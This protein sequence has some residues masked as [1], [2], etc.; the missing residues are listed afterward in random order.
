MT[1]Q[2]SLP[3]LSPAQ[4][5]PDAAEAV[6]EHALHRDTVHGSSSLTPTQ[7][8]EP[9]NIPRVGAGF[10][11][12]YMFAYF[13]LNLVMLMPA[14]FSL[15]Y[16]VQLI[17]PA[18]K[19]TSLGLVIGLGGI[20]GLVLGPI[21][22]VL[23]DGTRLAWGRR[24]PW[25]IGGL[26]LA[27]AGALAVAVVPT[28]PLMIVGWSICQLAVA[29]IS[30]GFNPVLAERVPSAQRGKVGALGG[31]AASFAGVGASLIGSFLTGNIML[32]FM[33]P[34][35]VFAVGVLLFIFV[36]RDKPAPAGTPRLA[37]SDVFKSFWFN[38]R[39]H[40][41][42]ALV[43]L[44]KF[45]LQFGFSF[46]STFSFYFLLD[47][48]GFTP[49]QAGQSLAA[50]GG[51]SLL[52]MMGFAVFGGFLSDRLKRRKP[53]IYLASTLI[54]AGLITVSI[55]PDIT[56]FIVG[57][58]LLSA[59]TG[60]FTS[61]DLAMATDVLPEPEKAGKYMSIYYLSSGIPGALAPIIAP[62]IIAVGGG[63]NYP[64][65]FITGAILAVGTAVTTWRIRGV[66]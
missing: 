11:A 24:R 53:F 16:K 8:P 10:I 46:F 28:V 27:T 17:D 1:T 49:E 61:V 33:L 19:D 59:G 7:D 57:G 30:A 22:G 44:G 2:P 63:G 18:G 58:V 48:L 64:A 51:I 56:L 37:V 29:V 5:L 26:L 14:L 38:P 55:A 4:A 36:I 66:R 52:A 21:A 40:A 65:L 13:G 20:I 54:A 25:I 31:V 43:F 6:A 3:D 35:L 23:S 12:T 60:A 42:F 39:E 41:D 62:V 32:L 50:A 9:E 45:L 47:R 34:P 15:A